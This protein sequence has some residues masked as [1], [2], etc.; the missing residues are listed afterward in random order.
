M[1][2]GTRPKSNNSPHDKKMLAYF[3]LSLVDLLARKSFFGGRLLFV[4]YVYV[5]KIFLS[6]PA[7]LAP[8]QQQP[9]HLGS[10]V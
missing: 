5:Y 7:A 9:Q 2:M 6:S 10:T 3:Y 8:K 4:G 1:E